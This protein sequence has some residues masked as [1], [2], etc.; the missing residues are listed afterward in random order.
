MDGG[1]TGRIESVNAS[2]LNLLVTGGFVP[3][4][5]PIALGEESEPLNIDGDRAAGSLSAG[6]SADVVLFATNVEGLLIEGKVV[7]RLPASEVPALLP[8]IGFGMQK[9]VM[10]ASEAVRQGVREAIIC[11]G[12]RERPIERALAHE[13]CTVIS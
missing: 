7:S 1:Y 8:K 5:S 12:V 10:A 9:K 4:V 2:L 11:S 13:E 3:V 6:I